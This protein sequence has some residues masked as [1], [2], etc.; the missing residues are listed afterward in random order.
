MTKSSDLDMEANSSSSSSGSNTTTSTSKSG[1]EEEEE[2]SDLELEKLS[3]DPGMFSAI[4]ADPDPGSGAFLIPG[5]GMDK[6]N[7]EPDP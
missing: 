6:K 5:F 1:D 7:Q 3:E 4:V 2:E